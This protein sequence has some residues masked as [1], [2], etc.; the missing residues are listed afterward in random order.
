LGILAGSHLLALISLG[1]IA[2]PLVV[3]SLLAVLIP[4]S[5][6]RNQTR[7]A[8]RDSGRF[9]QRLVYQS[10]S[11][12]TLGGGDGV[13]QRARLIGSYVHPHLILLNF[14]RVR[15]TRRS[16]VILA[17][18]ADAESIRRLRVFLRTAS[19]PFSNPSEPFDLRS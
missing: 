4:C 13:Q 18:S 15:W 16:V 3:K 2:V 14:A 9:V 7:F 11:G 6:H 17:D 10:D 1:T 12:W 5:W 19:Q 8:K